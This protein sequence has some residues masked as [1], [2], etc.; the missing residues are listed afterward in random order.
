MKVTL[1]CADEWMR[2]HPAKESRLEEIQAKLES[3]FVSGNDDRVLLD[4][5]YPRF[6]DELF[7]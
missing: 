5:D 2:T 4:L 3:R 1:A 7:D 6:R